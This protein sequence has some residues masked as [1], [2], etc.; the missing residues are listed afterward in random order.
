MKKIVILLLAFV[1]NSCNDGNF[2]V[3]SFDFTET[4]NQ[5]GEY[6]LYRTNTDKTE[7]ITIVLS[8]SQINTTLGTESYPISS[9]IQVNYRIFDSAIGSDYFCQTIP[10]AT[11]NVLKELN[12]TD[13]EISITTTAIKENDVVTGYNYDINITNLLF[14]DSD[15]KIFYE[16]YYFGIFSINI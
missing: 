3:P 8:P 5:C 13:G 7:V 10:P 4:V 1:L 6:L 2:D 11:P 14:N 12:A 15:S 16:T 9:L